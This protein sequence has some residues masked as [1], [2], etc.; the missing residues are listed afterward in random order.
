MS[1]ILRRCRR[2]PHTYLDVGC[3]DGRFLRVLEK[4]GVPRGG[5]Y[6]LE[7]DQHVVDELRRQGYTGVFCERVEETR[8]LPEGSIHLATMFHV[9]EHVDDPGAVVRQIS[10]WLSPGGIFAL[11]TPNLDSLDARIFRRTYWGGYHIPRH[12]NLFTPA[13]IARLLTQN[14]LE[15]V[16]TIFQTGHSFWMYSLHHL[17]RYEGG[18]R[19]RA[20]AWFDPIRSLFGIASFTAF[21]LVRGRLGSKTSAMLVICRKAGK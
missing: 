19:P 6:G 11:E 4:M 9:I 12:W 16:E 18:S 1:V 10:R 5:L 20:G 7:L 15:V 2:R 14:G 21:D 13:T 3:G 17:V 8:H